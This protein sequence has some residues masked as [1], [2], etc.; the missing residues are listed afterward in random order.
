MVKGLG[1]CREILYNNVLG[2]VSSM[3]CKQS[4]SRQKDMVNI[5][6]SKDIYSG[7]VGELKQVTSICSTTELSP[8][9]RG[10]VLL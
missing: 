7:D 5:A 3:N 9:L 10:F 2:K 4:P 1:A 8:Q 6:K